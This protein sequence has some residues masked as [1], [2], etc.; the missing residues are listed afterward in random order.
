MPLPLTRQIRLRHTSQLSDRRSHG[1][2]HR[3]QWGA[4]WRWRKVAHTLHGR[5]RVGFEAVVRVRRVDGRVRHRR[6]HGLVEDVAFL[7]RGL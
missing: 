4:R 3:R 6:A 1:R 2:I 5:G 7:G